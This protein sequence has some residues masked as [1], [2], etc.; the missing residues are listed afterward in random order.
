M[1]KKTALSSV[2]IL[3]SLI[4]FGQERLTLEYYM[5]AG[6]T[7]DSSIPVPGSIGHEVGEW[8]VTHDKLAGYMKLLGDLSGRAVW[9]DYGKSW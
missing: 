8:H 3:V 4:S 6:M 9:E 1:M 2:I 7:F 5:P